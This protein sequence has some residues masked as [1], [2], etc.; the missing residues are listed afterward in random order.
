[1]FMVMPAPQ[2][3]A[4]AMDGAMR[5][6][7]TSDNLLINLMVL[8]KDRM[9]E[10]RTYFE[11][12]NGKTLAEWIEGDCSGDYKDTLVMLANRKCIKF[13][14]VET[15]LT[16]PAPPSRKAALEKFNKCFN[17]MCALKRANPDD[18]LKI[19][20]NVQQEMASAF[21]FYGAPERSTR[22]PN[23][24]RTGL[25]NLT[26][27]CGF[28][29]AD[30][31]DDLDATL[32]EWDFSGTGDISWNDFV[33]EITT[34]VNDSNHFEAEPLPETY[35][36]QARSFDEEWKTPADSRRPDGLEDEYEERGVPDEVEINGVMV[37]SGIAQAFA[38]ALR[39][40]YVDGSGPAVGEFFDSGRAT[41]E[42]VG[43]F[44]PIEGEV[45]DADDKNAKLRELM[46]AWGL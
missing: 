40:E 11:E 12:K 25:W 36:D 35:D 16:V 44:D 42:M 2:A 17:E 6:V 34:R 20:E 43:A 8:A 41:G 37:P 46:E 5:G 1:M 27:D 14:G 9:D 32:R 26:N 31:M 45:R 15:G 21:Q 33:R 7:G 30:D 28:P 23:L 22:S 18:H 29:P 3:W 4:Y 24:D 39:A 13:C 38:D 10:V 19:P